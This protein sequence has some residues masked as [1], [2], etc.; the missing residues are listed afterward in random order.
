[1]LTIT[2]RFITFA[3]LFMVF[4]NLIK[5]HFVQPEKNITQLSFRWEVKFK[6]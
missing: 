4:V 2:I 1:V 3:L 5:L 6:I